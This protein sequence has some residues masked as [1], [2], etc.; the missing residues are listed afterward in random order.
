MAGRLDHIVTTQLGRGVAA[1]A[2]LTLSI[3]IG[4][5]VA[6]LYQSDV[7]Q[8]QMAVQKI[9]LL[10]RNSRQTISNA[11]RDYSSW[12][13]AY[14]YA[15]KPNRTFETEN[16]S[17]NNQQNMYAD[18]SVILSAP[19]NVLFATEAMA[20]DDS[21]ATPPLR[22]KSVLQVIATLPEWRVGVLLGKPKTYLRL[23]DGRPVL[24]AVAGITDS[25]EKAEYNGL[26]V[27][28]HFLDG[29]DL[30]ELEQVSE[31]RLHFVTDPAFASRLS[32]NGLSYTITEW[33]QVQNGE[34]PMWIEVSRIFDWRQRLVLIVSIVL[35]LGGMLLLGG[36][37][38]RHSLRKQVISRIETFSALASQGGQDQLLRWPDRGM[39]E[40][41]D[42]AQ[43]FN[44]LLDRVE[45][46]HVALAK[47]AHT[48]ALT[49]LGNRRALERQLSLL[50]GLK[51]EI[52][53][54]LMLDLDGFKLV[55]DSL[56]H[57]AGDLLLQRV[58]DRIRETM[59]SDDLLF[60]MGGDEFAMLLLGID[61]T[62]AQ[63]LGERLLEK[64]LQ[65][66][67]CAGLELNIS[68]SI[69][70]AEFSQGEVADLMQYADLAMYAAKNEGKARVRR[71]E[72]GMGTGAYEQLRI[73]QDLRAALVQHRFESWFQPVVDTQTNK[74]VAVEMLARWRN[75]DQI[76]PPSVF[77]RLAEEIGLID[78]LSEQLLEQ[79]LK[80][81]PV[82]RREIPDLKL[83]VNLSPVQFSDPLLAQKVLAQVA[84]HSLP[85]SALV[86]ELTENAMLHYPEL[87]E[88]TMTRFV[89]AG[90]GI[91][92]DDFGTGYS[93]MARL[94]KLPFD[95]V[96]LDRSFVQALGEGE[97]ALAQSVY[98][99]AGN[100]GLELIA[101]GVET[102]R[103]CSALVAMGYHQFQGYL[104]AK[105]MPLVDLAPWLVQ[106][107][108][109]NLTNFITREQ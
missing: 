18:F 30:A 87:V 50:V 85:A 33:V 84:A 38:L 13:D 11:V 24:L 20:E 35:G 100:M 14:A 64:L 59:R 107:S 75:G 70:I 36:R 3:V 28:G 72:P 47:Q 92:L 95:T 1:V 34:Y 42:L 106:A 4:L 73:E 43:A 2:L 62:Q 99:M 71:Y 90:T 9:L 31:A 67:T 5:S 78:R 44:R 109:S 49:G 53:S 104:F 22:S 51:G 48:D 68:A 82:M 55:N 65:P 108:S 21:N 105:P 23:V 79:G 96:K 77:I 101:E 16:F 41:D 56:G 17:A 7:N 98:D 103:E 26:M 76:V 60:R 61:S 46:A 39:D 12:N 6:M 69:G 97:P 89:A 74:V 83:F 66:I 58:A 88:Q 57:A 15:Q 27:M 80:A 29:D 54:M 10:E 32:F 8:I 94:H 40:L 19:H 102:V 37:L 25:A 81:L 63:M 93:S 91:Q 45:L 52:G 86:I